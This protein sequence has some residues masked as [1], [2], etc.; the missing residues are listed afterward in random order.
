MIKNKIE[1]N[2]NNGKPN[3]ISNTQNNEYATVIIDHN[4]Y[5]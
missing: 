3:E 2:T 5:I 1:K 4:V